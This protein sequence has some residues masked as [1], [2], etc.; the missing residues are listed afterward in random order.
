[1]LI[2]NLDLT[3]KIFIILFLIFLLH[4]MLIIYPNNNNNNKNL[5]LSSAFYSVIPPLYFLT[6]EKAKSLAS[7]MEDGRGKQSVHLVPSL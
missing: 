1:M 2:N 3:I 4:I 5:T 7:E 6:E